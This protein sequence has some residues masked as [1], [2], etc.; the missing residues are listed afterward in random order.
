MNAAFI[1]DGYARFVGD[2]VIDQ[3]YGRGRREKLAGI[4]RLHPEI[5][6]SQQ[7]D[8][9]RDVLGAV[10]VVFSTWG[11]PCLDSKQLD[12]MPNLK[13]LFYAAGATRHFRQPLLDRGIKVCSATAANAI[14]VA[15]FA[16]SQIL[17]AGAGYFRNSRECTDPSASGMA[18]SFRGHG[19]FEGRVAILGNGTV[20]RTLQQF[21]SHHD[22]EVVVVPSREAE[23]TLSLEEAFA[24]A[25]AVL[26]LFPDVDELAGIYDERLFCSMKDSAVFIN[27]GRGRQVNEADLIKAMKLRPDLTALLDVQWPEPPVAGS[28]LY[29]LPNIRLSAHIAGAKSAE[30]V[31]LADY[32]IE[33]F[34]RFERG[35]ALKYE[36]QPDQL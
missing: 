30:L 36:V 20:S 4:A 33:D 22:L 8:A 6:S 35:E 26:N 1:N 15:E 10:E 5:I 19:N 25:F 17:L 7:F 31:R 11:F 16:L 32:M 2:H 3:V 34:H 12:R 23:R 21:L 29:T 9:C 24:T 18:G 13:A 27:C 28:E 14:P